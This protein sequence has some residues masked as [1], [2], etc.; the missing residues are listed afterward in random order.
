MGEGDLVFGI[1]SVVALLWP[2]YSGRKQWLKPKFEHS[3]LYINYV[4]IIQEN[5][6]HYMVV[7]ARALWFMKTV[8]IP[9]L[10]SEKI[11]LSQIYRVEPPLRDPLR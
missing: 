11:T 9:T 4:S 10:T 2:G 7:T 1:H 8:H 6:V 3:V 5:Y